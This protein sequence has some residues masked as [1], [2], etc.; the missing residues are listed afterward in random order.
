MRSAPM[1][2]LL[3]GLAGLAGAG[4]L[5][6]CLAFVAA[7]APPP[8]RAVAQLD[9][10]RYA[11][12]WYE[13]AR[14]PNRGQA[15]C[16]ADATTMVWPVDERSLK[17]VRECRDGAD[18]P[19]FTVGEAVADPADRSGARFS[20]THRPSLPGWWPR[21]SESHWVVLLDDEY[22]YAVVSDPARRSLW[23]LSRTPRLAPDT[24]A[25]IVGELRERRYPVDRLVPTPHRAWHPAGLLPVGRRTRLIV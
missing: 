5:A 22:R 2:I 10:Q 7:T 17:L 1:R 20:L 24:Y 21:A 15:R 19:V 12:T 8:V 18:R 23:I 6:A 11:G 25:S 16:A 13:I 3:A 9:L 4:A 14:L